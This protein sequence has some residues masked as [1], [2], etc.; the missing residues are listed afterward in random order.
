MVSSLEEGGM[1]LGGYD[2]PQSTPPSAKRQ[3]SNNWI[4][5]ELLILV[6]AK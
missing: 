1:S 6:V 3:R 2:A 5:R 4:E